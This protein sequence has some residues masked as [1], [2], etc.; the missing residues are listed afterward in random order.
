[1][2]LDIYLY[3]RAE[4]E[5]N[6]AHSDGWDRVW[7]EFHD[8]QTGNLKPGKT[9]EEYSAAS[10][11]VPPYRG[12]SDRPSERYPDHLFKR[13]YL[14]SS[15]NDSGFN[16]AVPNMLAR[17]DVDLYGIFEPVIGAD[18]EPYET[19]LTAET[20]PA[21]EQ[22]KERALAVAAGLRATDPLRVMHVS[23]PILG[24]QEHMWNH[25]PSEDEVLAWYREEQQKR[26]AA[27][28]SASRM[29]REEYG[30]MT[31]KGEV[32]G[33]T[34]GMEILAVTMGANPLRQFSQQFP[35]N[36]VGGQ[37]GVAPQVVLVYRQTEEGTKSYIESAEII[38]EFCDEAIM[39]IKADGSCH[40]HWSG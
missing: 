20:I 30:Y 19:L 16:R 10:A 26:Q 24:D 38:A 23:A 31:A 37:M 13:N 6:K 36:T 29:D 3:T 2:G 21:L 17:E 27:V 15:Y 18:P 14:R 32:F 39:L 22:V 40:M 7:N 35:P 25:L 28:E 4:Q 1:M 34:K 8:E 5:A 33:F 11:Q 12:S 9:D